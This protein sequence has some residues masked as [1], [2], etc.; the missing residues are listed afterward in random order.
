MDFSSY[1]N[2]PMVGMTMFNSGGGGSNSDLYYL[3]GMTNYLKGGGGTI[4]GT[5]GVS[6]WGNQTTNN[7]GQPIKTHTIQAPQYKAPQYKAQQ[8]KQPQYKQPP[9]KKSKPQR[10]MMY[11][12]RKPSR[13]F[14][15]PYLSH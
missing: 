10:Q 8:Y 7:A 4:L 9:K 13:Q 1:L 6:L 14:Q 12:Q 5:G 15:D 3:M 11:A 2:N